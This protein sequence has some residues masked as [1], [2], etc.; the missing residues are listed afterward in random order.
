MMRPAE[1]AI[2]GLVLALVACDQRPQPPS[3]LTIELLDRP[4]L[5]RYQ[6]E[7]VGSTDLRRIL[8]DEAE[9][10]RSGITGSSA[11]MRVVIVTPG[12]SNDRRARQLADY[13]YGIGLQAVSFQT[14]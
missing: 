9:R 2:L 1:A 4:G 6:G 12:G 13:C 10:T 11:G 8:R 3:L 5:V 14:Y 7:E